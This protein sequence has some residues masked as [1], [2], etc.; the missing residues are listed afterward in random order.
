MKQELV[1]GKAQLVPSPENPSLH[2]QVKPSMVSVHVA[3]SSQ[4]CVPEA[5]SSTVQPPTTMSPPS[6]RQGLYVGWPVYTSNDVAASVS[7]ATASLQSSD[8]LVVSVQIPVLLTN[9]AGSGDGSLQSTAGT[10]PSRDTS[11]AFVRHLY[12]TVPP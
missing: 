3:C 10:Q 5:H 2:E 7:Q 12:A 9:P 8:V 6:A 11:A 4:L 1:L